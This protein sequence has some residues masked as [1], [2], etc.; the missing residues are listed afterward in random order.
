MYIIYSCDIK[1]IRRT[2][3]SFIVFLVF[4]GNV[5]NR[6]GNMIFYLPLLEHNYPIRLYTLKLSLIQVPEIVHLIKKCTI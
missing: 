2:M 5:T 1:V 4:R 3:A 6:N